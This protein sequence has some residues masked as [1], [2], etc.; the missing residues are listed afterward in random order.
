MWLFQSGSIQ[1]WGCKY[2]ACQGPCNLTVPE[3]LSYDP[4]L[5]STATELQP[6]EAVYGYGGGL[7][8]MYLSNSTLNDTFVFRNEA[9]HSIELPQVQVALTQYLQQRVE[10]KSGTCTPVPVYTHAILGVAPYVSSPDP[11]VQNSTGPS[12]RQNLLDRGLISAAVQSLWFEKAPK[13]LHATFTGVGLLGGIDTSKF[14][15]PLVKV[16]RLAGGYSYNEYYTHAANVSFNG[17][18]FGFDRSP[19]TGVQDFC[20]IDSGAQGDGVNPVDQKAFLNAT[21]LVVNP[22]RTGG[23]E[24]LSWP[25]PCDDVPTDSALEY[26]FGGVDPKQNVTI[27]VPFRTYAR[28]QEPT[29]DELGWCTMAIYLRGCDLGAP[30]QSAAFF[31][32]DDEH[33]EIALAQGGVAEQG[34]GVN[35]TS[36]IL[37][38]P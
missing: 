5:S 18:S 12:F 2:L 13:D 14:E 28:F 6:W 33:S 7:G 34:S 4:S 10:D 1:N 17:V 16:P 29:D 8:K 30:F 25:G 3:E 36:V 23:G 26:T 22:K 15:G 32:A 38:I 35:T 11:T 27:K 19:Q 20:I 24:Y 37:R 31:A 21:G 9:G